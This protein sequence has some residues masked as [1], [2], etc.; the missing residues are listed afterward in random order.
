MGDLIK[1]LE[2]A[3]E[4]GFNLFMEVY[5]ACHGLVHFTDAERMTHFHRFTNLVSVGAWL[6]AA[7]S[8]GRDARHRRDLLAQ[9]HS[10]CVAKNLDPVQHAA[11]IVCLWVVHDLERARLTNVG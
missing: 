1:R 6:D 11:R 5:E 7:M 10:E 4:P 8:L 9:A 3:R 2:K